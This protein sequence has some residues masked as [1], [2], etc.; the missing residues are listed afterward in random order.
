MPLWYVH[1]GTSFGS[2]VW[3]DGKQGEV[4]VYCK[5]TGLFHPDANITY[6]YYT[7]RGPYKFMAT[8]PGEAG[9]EIQDG[10]GEFGASRAGLIRSYKGN[11]ECLTVRN[12][13]LTVA[14]EHGR[15]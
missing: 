13:M 3:T 2:I 15:V 11:D 9:I 7:K 4:Y 1:E 14:A 12:V 5:E 8:V 10:I 6:S